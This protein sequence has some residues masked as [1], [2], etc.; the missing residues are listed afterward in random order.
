MTYKFS[1]EFKELISQSREIAIDLGYDYISTI[2]FFLADCES[3]RAD[4][5]LKFAFED[6]AGY[7]VFKKHYIR[8]KIVI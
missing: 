1:P 6:E 4:S 3:K 8:E 5:L 7:Q 2:H